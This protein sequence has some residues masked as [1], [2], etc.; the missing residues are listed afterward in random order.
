MLYLKLVDLINHYQRMSEQRRSTS[1][2][3]GY[4]ML[5]DLEG[6]LD[7]V[8]ANFNIR[9]EE[10][11]AYFIELVAKQNK[12]YEFPRIKVNKYDQHYNMKKIIDQNLHMLGIDK[13]SVFR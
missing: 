6:N 3:E 11:K 7:Y 9:D 5:R 8:K 4:Y 10:I 13:R 1:A 12:T 2:Y